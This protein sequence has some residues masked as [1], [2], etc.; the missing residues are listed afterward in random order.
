MEPLSYLSNDFVNS[1]VA[2]EREKVEFRPIFG[3]TAA[4]FWNLEEI[5]KTTLCSQRGKGGVAEK[6]DMTIGHVLFLI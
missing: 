6:K 1:A 4:L 3:E 2:S 5:R